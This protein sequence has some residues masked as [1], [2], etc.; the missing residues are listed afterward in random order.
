MKISKMSCLMIVCIT[1][2]C[3]NVTAMVYTECRGDVNA[4]A[5]QCYRYFEDSSSKENPSQE[6]CKVIQ[7]LDVQCVCPYFPKIFQRLLSIK[8]ALSALQ[9]CGN[10]LAPGTKCGDNTIP[11]RPGKD[12]R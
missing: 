10:P 11:P 5:R 1:L 9:F 8:K 3:A 2:F 6:C 12:R 7:G 4:L